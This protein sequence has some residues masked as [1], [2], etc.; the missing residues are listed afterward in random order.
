M[1]GWWGLGLAAWA[2]GGCAPATVQLARTNG[3][4]NVQVGLEPG[5]FG[6]AADDGDVGALPSFNVAARVGV[7]DRVDVGGRLGTSLYEL[8]LK[9]MLTD[10]DDLDGVAASIAPATVVFPIGVDGESVV[11]WNTRVPVLIGVPV[12]RSEL[13]LGPT[14]SV[15]VIT[16]SGGAASALSLGGQVGFAAR[17]GERFWLVPQVDFGVPVLGAASAG[18]GASVGIGASGVVFGGQLGLLFGGR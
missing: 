13:T 2:V 18:E 14:G 16:A 3:A 17:A 1:K 10:P 12:G 4:G 8:Q 11:F 9:V 5:L 15:L 6:A 7:S